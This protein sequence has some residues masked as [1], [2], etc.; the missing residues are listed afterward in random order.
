[1]HLPSAIAGF[2]DELFKLVV[3]TS[4]DTNVL[5]SP[6]S[7]SATL[8]MLIAGTRNISRWQLLNVLHSDSDASET[9]FD[10][11]YSSLLESYESNCRDQVDNSR[12]GL[13]LCC[14]G[15]DEAGDQRGKKEQK[16]ILSNLL[17]VP[18]SCDVKENYLDELKSKYK[19]EVKELDFSKK[20]HRIQRQVDQWAK[21]ATNRCICTFLDE[22]PT[23]ETAL[24]IF[25][26]VYF[27]CKWQGKFQLE[28]TKRKFYLA[29]G[30]IKKIPF[31][32]RTDNLKYFEIVHG[33]GQ[34]QIQVVEIPYVGQ[35]SMIVMRPPN[36]KA[37]N[38]LV[39]EK[40]LDDLLEQFVRHGQLRN[41]QLR[42]PK[43]T[44]KYKSSMNGILKNM[45][46]MDIF[47]ED[48]A[49]F[50]GISNDERLHV[51]QIDHLTVIEVDEKGVKTA[52]ET[53]VR[54][55][56]QGSIFLEKT[57]VS[58]TENRTGTS[59]ESIST[60]LEIIMDHPFVFV[61][62]DSQRKLSILLGKLQD[63]TC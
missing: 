30:S 17:L 33:P 24:M 48:S 3:N 19:V 18:Q 23:E 35:L 46:A 7:L 21:K 42:L 10:D 31:V 11:F 52:P 9:N 36:C 32:T 28:P 45:C 55:L 61:I 15:S 50:T 58:F 51:S 38:E 29:S 2:G 60:P 59:S 27:K 57:N 12:C 43:F 8:A 39:A 56:T 44:L 34:D 49:D 22:P 16:L 54:K 14:R 47:D 63:P 25:N 20:K 26:C 53:N 1:M 37:A 4:Q 62:Y 5:V 13:C 41:I 6:L 40:S